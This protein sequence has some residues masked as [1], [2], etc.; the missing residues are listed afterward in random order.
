M[1]EIQKVVP[2][3]IGVKIPKIN[4]IIPKTINPIT[5]EIP[6]SLNKPFFLFLYPFAIYTINHFP[7][8]PKEKTI[9]WY[10]NRLHSP[11]MIFAKSSRVVEYLI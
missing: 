7:L 11:S 4:R 1:I 3:P 9:T 8:V 5:I 6:P 10:S 2:E